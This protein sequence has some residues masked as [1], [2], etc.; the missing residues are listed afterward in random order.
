MNLRVGGKWV[1][2]KRLGAG[3]FGEIYSGEYL[4]T[5]EEAAIKLE[6]DRAHPPQLMN[7]SCV[8]RVLP[9]DVGIPDVHWYGVE[10]DC[11]VLVFDLLGK[12]F[13]ELFNHCQKKFSLK[14]VLMI[15]DQLLARIEYIHNKGIIHRDIKP[16]NFMTGRMSYTQLISGCRSR[17]RYD[18]VDISTERL[19]ETQ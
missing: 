2:R 16:D 7:E 6:S 8:Y 10:G 18:E 1:L 12:S 5:R 13:E 9:G 3:S 11:N 4:M 14:T 19:A 15:A 17:R